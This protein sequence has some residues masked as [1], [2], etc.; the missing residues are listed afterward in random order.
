MCEVGRERRRSEHLLSRPGRSP[1]G[2]F[3]PCAVSVRSLASKSTSSSHVV[4][5]F[6]ND[7][8][9]CRMFQSDFQPDLYL[10]WLIAAF[11]LLFS[12][13]LSAFSHSILPVDIWPYRKH[14]RLLSDRRKCLLVI[15]QVHAGSLSGIR[16]CQGYS[17]PQSTGPERYCCPLHPEGKVPSS[18]VWFFSKESR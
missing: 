18:I 12:T 11:G 14:R 16:Q 13:Y 7:T 8:L 1:T 15:G 4:E 10:W 2:R 9:S 3:V 6:W 17:V 5:V